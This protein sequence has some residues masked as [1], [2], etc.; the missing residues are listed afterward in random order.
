VGARAGFHLASTCFE[1]KPT[2]GT[3]I[4]ALTLGGCSTPMVKP[5]FRTVRLADWHRAAR[6]TG[7]RV[8]GS[9]MAAKNAVG[10]PC[11]SSGPSLSHNQ[12]RVLAIAPPAQGQARF[13]LA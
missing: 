6:A 11:C 13:T 8:R 1:T 2:L 4:N 9:L 3:L 12:P 5:E 7:G 10:G